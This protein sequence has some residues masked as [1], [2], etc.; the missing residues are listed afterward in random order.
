MH[1]SGE[2]AVCI[3][4][5][6]GG[7]LTEV[8]CLKA[9]YQAYPHFYVLNDRVLLPDDMKDR[10]HFITHAERDWLVA[11]NFWEALRILQRERP[12]AILSTGAGPAV[13]FA[14][15]GRAL[16]G[17]RV[18]FVETITRVNR[19]SLTARLVYP[20]AHRF[21]YQHEALRRYFPRGIY[22]GALV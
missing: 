22:A 10:T 15:M 2:R 5:S 3:V 6:C 17:A 20:I 12:R 18:I 4:S 16:L 14:L 21:Y 9:A 8:R 11:V 13:P 19:P 7:H 1:P